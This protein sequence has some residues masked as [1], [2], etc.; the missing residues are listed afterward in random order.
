[1]IDCNI[2]YII[3]LTLLNKMAASMRTHGSW[4]LF[5]DNSSNKY[6][7]YFRIKTLSQICLIHLTAFSIK[8]IKVYCLIDTI[9]NVEVRVCNSFVNSKKKKLRYLYFL[10]IISLWILTWQMLQ[11]KIKQNLR[12]KL[13]TLKNELQ[14]D[15]IL[16][17]V[18]D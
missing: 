9:F 1:M 16:T 2:H 6:F 13:L 17:Q 7:S 8:K 14:T 12:D 15:M 10:Y 18:L 3:E 11:N 5:H 4:R